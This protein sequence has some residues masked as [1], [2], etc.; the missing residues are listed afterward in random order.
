MGGCVA[1]ATTRLAIALQQGRYSLE[2]RFTI[3]VPD[4]TF[5]GMRTIIIQYDN[6]EGGHQ[7]SIA[8]RTLRLI[9]APRFFW[10]LIAV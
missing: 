2:T 9:A 3:Y 6:G 7:Q 5:K 8:R 10:G 1:A 4:G